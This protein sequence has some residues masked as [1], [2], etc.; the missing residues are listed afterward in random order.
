MTSQAEGIF[1]FLLATLSHFRHNPLSFNIDGTTSNPTFTLQQG[2]VLGFF[3]D[4]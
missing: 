1:L 3:F 2:N 4:K